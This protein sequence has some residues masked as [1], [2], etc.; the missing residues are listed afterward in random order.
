MFPCHSGFVSRFVLTPT[1]RL[2]P[3]L[4]LY[5]RRQIIPSWAGDLDGWR[6]AA[7]AC[8]EGDR[9]QYIAASSRRWLRGNQ[10]PR[11]AILVFSPVQVGLHAGSLGVVSD[12]SLLMVA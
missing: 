1:T 11:A 12:R 9:T 8:V 10:R 2:V 5:R 3:P 7:W 6:L 4:L